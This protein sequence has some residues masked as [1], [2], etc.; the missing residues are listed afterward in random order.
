M[1]KTNIFRGILSIIVILTMIS[2]CS[3]SKAIAIDHD[4]DVCIP[5][6]F[7]IAFPVVTPQ[8]INSITTPRQVP[9]QGKWKI[10]GTLPFPQDELNA[11][12][13]RPQQKELWFTTQYKI[14]RYFID[15]KQWKSYQVDD[16]NL[17]LRDIL[18]IADDGTVWGVKTRS[19]GTSHLGDS[20]PILI[21]Y[22]DL[23]DRFEDVQDASGFLQAPHVRM[24][25]NIAE[26]Q[27][28]LLWFFVDA[29][30]NTLVSFD[31]KT[32]RS[33]QHYYFK[34]AGGNPNVVI[35]PDGSVWFQDFANNELVQ[36]KP[37]TNETRIFKGTLDSANALDPSEY[38]FD[39]T[40]ANY[41]YF[42]HSERLWVANQGWLEFSSNGFPVWN[43]VVVSPVFVT[44]NGLLQSQY[45]ISLPYSAY[46]SS[47]GW[48]WF[49]SGAGIVRL[50]LEKGSWCL[51]TTGTSD[52]VEDNDHNLWIAVF[53]HLYKYPLQH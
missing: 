26:D 39:L 31:T 3:P 36:Y 41:I 34:I 14:Y 6:L 47:N 46:Q 11:V 19:S 15:Q 32:G 38:P 10:Q 29:G 50:E 16:L 44:D 13:I 27:S 7:D 4:S 9:P 20:I 8:A 24:I 43:Q 28:G 23:T 52:V 12:Y 17:I 45:I 49:T 48:Y 18:F 25:S 33:Q 51:M 40:E 30:K 2:A 22:N 1:A 53:G 42:D 37:A 5:P 35:G 21:R